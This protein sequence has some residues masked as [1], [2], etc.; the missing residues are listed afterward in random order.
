MTDEL[1]SDYTVRIT[2]ANVTSLAVICYEL[3]IRFLNEAMLNYK[4]EDMSGYIENLQ[5]A[6]KTQV[7]LMN[8]QK[9][10]VE[11]GADVMS[12]YIFINKHILDSATQKAPCDIDACIT[13]L[14][15]LKQAFVELA[16]TDMEG[17]IME[18]A[19]QIYRGL[20][21]G[22]G[23]LNDSMDPIADVNRGFKA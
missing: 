1:I 8:M 11:A 12:L 20:T 15:N 13:I 23:Y 7:E 18:N 9:T 19:H 2:Q 3:E 14:N 16:K 5:L 22:K 10:D 21:Y 6:S 4:A 17:P